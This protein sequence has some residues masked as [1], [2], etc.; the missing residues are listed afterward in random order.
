M[1]IRR[2]TVDKIE[3]DKDGNSIAYLKPD[4]PAREDPV[5][6]LDPKVTVEMDRFLT[7]QM[8]CFIPRTS[9]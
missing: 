7:K 4:N 8:R 5:R 2:A 6:A 3:D 1:Q 9:I